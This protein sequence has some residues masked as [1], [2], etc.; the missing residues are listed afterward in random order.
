MVRIDKYAQYF[1]ITSINHSKLIHT[2][3]EF[4]KNLITYRMALL[5]V[6]NQRQPKVITKPDKYFYI[7]ETKDISHPVRRDLIRYPVTLLDSMLSFLGDRGIRKNSIDIVTHEPFKGVKVDINS[8]PSYTP[9]DYQEEYIKRIVET[10][11]HNLLIDLFT[12]YGK[13]LRNSTLIKTKTGWCEIQYLDV[14]DHV[15]G[16][17]GKPTTVTG[18]YPQGKRQLYQVT[19]EDGRSLDA[20]GEHLWTVYGNI[21]DGATLTTK[22]ID[23]LLYNK[24]DILYIDLPS[25]IDYKVDCLVSSYQDLSKYINDLELSSIKSREA[26]VDILLTLSPKQVSDNIEA[27]LR[28]LRSLG[29]I[30]SYAN[31]SVNINM[32]ATKIRIDSI[33]LIDQDLATCISV[34]APDKLYIADN[35]IV[36]HNTFISMYSV[37]KIGEKFSLF[38]LPRYIDKWIG[39]ITTLTDIKEDEI[40]VIKGLSMMAAI[41][42]DPSIADKYK[43]FVISLT[44]LNYLIKKYLNGELLEHTTKTPEDL[45]PSLGTSIVLNDESHQEF[46]NVYKVMLFSNVKLFMGITATLVSNDKD[47]TKMHDIMFPESNRASNI[48]KY[49]TYIHVSSVRFRFL[50]RKQI[51][52]KNSFGYNQAILENSII[53]NRRTLHNYL[54]MIATLL[55]G[56][57]IRKKADKDKCII[58]MGTVNMCSLMVDHLRSLH[59]NLRISKYTEEDDYTTIEA[60]DIIVSTPASAST[61]LDIP[62]LI[63]TIQTVNV[64]SVAANL[65]TLGRLRDLKDKK[66]DFVYIWSND[67]PSHRNYNRNRIRLFSKR[68]K[69]IRSIEYRDLV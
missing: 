57:Y 35:Y 16:K 43:C 56:F 23:K 10:D 28:V 15:I 62:N 4:N 25:P 2:L 27:I 37:C 32:S 26:F 40:L 42:N 11:K 66:M 50:Y 3:Y 49:K 59:K 48:V 68:A 47:V 14:G 46:A 45:F 30:A 9:K 29:Y 63:T 36:T 8:N 7:A 38:V 64:D 1:T 33:K 39:D 13:A 53:R 34:D 52:F 5:R 60:S 58:F 18:V 55:S 44:S 41:L 19:L 24:D 21:I 22:D 61:A 6:K 17:D 54:K 67:V 51:K 69:T 12:G 20:D 65:Q 31:G